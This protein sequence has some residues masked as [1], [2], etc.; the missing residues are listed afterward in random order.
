MG[1]IN[2]YKEL[3]IWQKGMQIAKLTYSLASDFPND[4]IYSLTNQVK[5]SCVSVPSNIAEGYGRNSTLSYMNFIKIS[6]GSLYELETQLI[7]AKR[8]NFIANDPLY[9]SIINLIAEEGK[10]INTLLNKLKSK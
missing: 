1:E 3:L 10:M 9:D 6:R 5:R 7:L 8:L 2:S 4:E